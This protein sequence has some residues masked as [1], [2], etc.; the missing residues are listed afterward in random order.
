MDENNSHQ[1]IAIFLPIILYVYCF[2]NKDAIRAFQ[3]TDPK[4][5][6]QEQRAKYSQGNFEKD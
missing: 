4:S 3:Q 5:I 1:K 6:I 2:S